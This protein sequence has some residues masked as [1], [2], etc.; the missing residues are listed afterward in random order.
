MAT[1]RYEVFCYFSELMVNNFIAVLLYFMYY[2]FTCTASCLTEICCLLLYFL[3]CLHFF[4]FAAQE[5]HKNSRD[6]F[7]ACEKLGPQSPGAAT[8]RVGVVLTGESPLSTVKV[9]S[10][11][12]SK[13]W[14]PKHLKV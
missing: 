4:S 7:K 1:C 6:A 14:C 12:L 10:T 5:I 3:S 11:S 9:K 8:A 2:Y 13:W